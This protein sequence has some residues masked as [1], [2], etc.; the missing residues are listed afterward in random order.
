MIPITCLQ[1]KNFK[2]FSYS[3]SLTDMVEGLSIQT[4]QHTVRCC[5]DR[6]SSGCVVQQTQLTEHFS[7][8]VILQKSWTRLTL[9]YQQ[10]QKTPKFL[11][12]LKYEMINKNN[13]NGKLFTE[14]KRI[15]KKPY[16][17]KLWSTWGRL[18]STRTTHPR[19]LPAWSR[20]LHLKNV[21]RSLRQWQ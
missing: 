6:S 10:G 7:W 8:L 1:S 17:G 13:L 3:I 14:K 18:Q 4:E 20:H 5:D 19:H 21:V 16:L 9:C 15:K 12:H 11:S 2:Y